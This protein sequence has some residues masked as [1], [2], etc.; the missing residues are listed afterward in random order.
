[1]KNKIEYLEKIG[2]EGC[3]DDDLSD[4]L[5]EYRIAQR[6]TATGWQFLFWSEET[7]QFLH[8]HLSESDFETLLNEKLA[9]L[10]EKDEMLSS[11]PYSFSD[12]VR[13]YGV[14]GSF[15]DFPYSLESLESIIY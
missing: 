7:N 8:T 2:F 11:F 1:M 12:F 5:L 15:G 3:A 13:E 10:P 6:K 9:A 14:D 4:S